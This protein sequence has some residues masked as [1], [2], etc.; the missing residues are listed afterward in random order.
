MSGTL[1]AHILLCFIY[2]SRARRPHGRTLS[3][4]AYGFTCGHMDPRVRSVH[5]GDLRDVDMDGCIRWLR[6]SA[7][8]YFVDLR[9]CLR[10]CS[11]RELQYPPQGHFLPFSLLLFGFYYFLKGG[12]PSKVHAPRRRDPVTLLRLQLS[13]AVQHPPR[14]LHALRLLDVV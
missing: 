6:G 5:C 7:L 4:S 3:L 10:G 11:A 9:A 8:L 14:E 1:A 13:P 12:D 2:L